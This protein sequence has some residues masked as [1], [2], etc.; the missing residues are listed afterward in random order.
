[1]S[2]HS[3]F[4]LDMLFI[5]ASHAFLFVWFLSVLAIAA[6]WAGSGLY[7]EFFVRSRANVFSLSAARKWHGSFQNPQTPSQEPLS[8]F[9]GLQTHICRSQKSQL[10]KIRL[11]FLS[12][13][14]MHFDGITLYPE[15]AIKTIANMLRNRATTAG[16]YV[17]LYYSAKSGHANTKIASLR[18]IREIKFPK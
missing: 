12:Q 2:S 1:M 14:V 3:C 6:S 16:I 13:K 15:R 17:L 10:D 18:Q 4:P 5:L 7:C 9:C 8:P 11:L